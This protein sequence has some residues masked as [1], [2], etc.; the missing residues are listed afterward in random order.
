MTILLAWL[1]DSSIHSISDQVIYEQHELMGWG[2][3]ADAAAVNDA[4]TKFVNTSQHD[5]QFEFLQKV[6]KL[7]VV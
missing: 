1:L 5:V 7:T 2:H 6:L 3:G 4:S